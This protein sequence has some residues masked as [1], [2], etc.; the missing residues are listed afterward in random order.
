MTE[1]H[2][3]VIKQSETTEVCQRR[4]EIR[5]RVSVMLTILESRR[6]KMRCPRNSNPI[7]YSTGVTTATNKKKQN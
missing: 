1:F 4:L 3:D 5:K 7:G 2:S 6:T